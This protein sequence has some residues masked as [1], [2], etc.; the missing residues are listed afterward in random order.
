[1]SGGSFSELRSKLDS[2]DVFLAGG[3][4][5]MKTAGATRHAARM[6]KVPVWALD[7][8]KIKELIKLRFPKAGT[9]PEQRK[10]AS[11]MVRL[12]YL[13]YRVGATTDV[14]AAELHM[15]RRMVEKIVH[16]LSK[17]MTQPLKPSHRP[18]KKGVGIQAPSG[19]IGDDSHTTL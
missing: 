17:A 16:K 10:L 18:K 3:H 9:D 5:I 4:R 11:R 13:Y 15:S 2:N 7:D 12:I 19:I 6:K 8:N 1:L 14:V